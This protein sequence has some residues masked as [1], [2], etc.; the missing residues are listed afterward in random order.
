MPVRIPVK[1]GFFAAN[2]QLLNKPVLGEKLEVPVHGAQAD[3]GH[4]GPSDLVQ[5]NRRGVKGE[6][7]ELLEHDLP[8][9]CVPLGF[10]ADH[11]TALPAIKTYYQ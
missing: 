7:P 2:L 4:T 10:P 8:L 11:E 9:P 6:L 5:L 3:L 1:P